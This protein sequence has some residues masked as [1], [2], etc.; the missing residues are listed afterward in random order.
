MDQIKKETK[1]TEQTILAQ[2][3]Q[4]GKIKDEIYE[5]KK[6][7]ENVEETLLGLLEST[8]GKLQN[9]G[10]QQV[11]SQLYSPQKVVHSP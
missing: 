3:K 7:R 10:S 9:G 2:L 4:V 11:E 5:E 1:E 6:D 8:C